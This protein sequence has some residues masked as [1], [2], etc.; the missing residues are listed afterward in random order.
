MRGWLPRN[1]LLFQQ[2]LGRRDYNCNRGSVAD[3]CSLRSGDDDRVRANCSW[4]SGTAAAAAPAA[5]ATST[6]TTAPSS[7]ASAAAT[8]TTA[9]DTGS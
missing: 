4:G 2:L 8:T 7:A 1:G 5:T 6:T 3:R 9:A